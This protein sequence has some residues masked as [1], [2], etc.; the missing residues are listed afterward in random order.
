MYKSVD[1]L[2][3]VVARV[4]GQPRSVALRGCFATGE[5][6]RGGETGVVLTVRL[7][8]RLTVSKHGGVVRVF[9]ERKF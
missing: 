1:L 3:G 5:D 2:A 4:E 8:S 7:A 6:V 9:F